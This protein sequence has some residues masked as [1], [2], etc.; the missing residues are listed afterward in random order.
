MTTASPSAL[1]VGRK[2]VA[3][4]QEHKDEQA[5]QE[6]Y[7]DDAQHVEACELGPDMPRV[8][9]GKEQLMKNVKQWYEVNEVHS[10]STEGPY[11]HGDDRFAAV[12]KVDLTSSAGPMAGQR[13]QMEEVGVYTVADGKI[14]RA[15]F[16]YDTSQMGG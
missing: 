6:L 8:T 12:M 15:E 14:T 4:C 2:L 1:E 11:A 3:L 10:S 5:M 7:A 13:Y 9:Q 16:F